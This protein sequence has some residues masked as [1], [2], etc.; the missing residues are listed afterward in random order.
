M[1]RR[2]DRSASRLTRRS[3][4]GVRRESRASACCGAE[5]HARTGVLRNS[6]NAGPDMCTS[7]CFLH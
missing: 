7:A 4:E 3:A 2:V 6:R 1:R 5:G